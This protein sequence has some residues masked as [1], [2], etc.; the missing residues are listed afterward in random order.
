[1]PPAPSPGPAPRPAPPAPR[2]G[3][4][5]GPGRAPGAGAAS[6]GVASVGPLPP[7][8]PP[9]AR[10]AAVGRPRP[11]ARRGR[12][13]LRAAPRH[14]ALDPAV[15]R[16]A[17]ER[18]AARRARRRPLALAALADRQD[19]APQGPPDARPRARHA[20]LPHPRGGDESVPRPAL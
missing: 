12:Y 17:H 16:L 3:G 6:R 8:A 1:M 13:R 15:V 18:A 7:A 14:L 10:P 9:A 5:P 19:G 11:P 2:R 20:R 4:S